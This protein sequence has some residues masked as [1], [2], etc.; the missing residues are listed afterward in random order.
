MFNLKFLFMANKSVLSK[1]QVSENLPRNAFN[2]SGYRNFSQSA[3]MLIP[4]FAE[5]C[6]AGTKGVLNR[7]IFTRA[8][9]VVSPAFPDVKQSVE[10]FKVPLRYLLSSWNDWKLNINDIGSTAIVTESNGVPD[11]SL[12]NNIPCM[13]FGGDSNGSTLADRVLSALATL[14]VVPSAQPKYLNNMFRLLQGLGYLKGSSLGSGSGSPISN[15][16]NLFKIAAYN[17]VYYDHFRNTTY[18]SNNPYTYNLDWLLNPNRSTNCTLNPA[19]NALHSQV[20]YDMFNLKYVN[21]KNDYYHNFFPSL[22]TSVSVP[23]GS[24]N[25]PNSVVGAS[26]G[27]TNTYGEPY[28]QQ[29]PLYQQLSPSIGSGL[30]SQSNGVSVS[31]QQIRAAFALDKLMRASAYTPKHV[32]DQIKARFGVDVGDKVSFESEKLGGFDNTIVFGEVTN[33]AASSSNLLGEVGGKGVSAKNFE[34]DIHFYCEEDS[35]IIGV[36]YIKPSPCYDFMED[37]W[38]DNLVKE[39]FWQPEFANLGLRPVYNETMN[40]IAYTIPYQRYKLGRDMNLGIF[41]SLTFEAGMSGNNVSVSQ[42]TGAL[43]NF[44]IHSRLPMSWQGPVSAAYFKVLPSHLDSIFAQAYDDT[45]GSP[46][47]DQFYYHLDIKFAVT[48]NMSIHGVPRL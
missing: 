37:E 9:Q 14:S 1:P 47:T 21:Y 5:P 24:W 12:P 31:V 35:I 11:L 42:L 46:Q 34:S 20:F 2:R 26:V 30:N 6:I 22:N 3:G 40:V 10:F 32:R 28:L 29:I 16:K 23:V 18:E 48:A 8:A 39:D 15:V 44:T 4:I 19:Q 43:S 17:K 38:D 7:S 25:L 13:N 41:N 45:Y 33:T 27:S 36:T